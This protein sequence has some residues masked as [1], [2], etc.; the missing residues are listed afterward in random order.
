[1]V[2]PLDIVHDFLTKKDRLSIWLTN[3]NTTVIEGTMIGFDEF[4]N[5]VIDN[6]TEVDMKTKSSVDLGRILLKGDNV[7]LMHPIGV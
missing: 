5:L 1:M 4:M 2:K 3:S 7:A 6:A